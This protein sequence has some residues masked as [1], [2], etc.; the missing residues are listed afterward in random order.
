MS[1]RLAPSADFPVLIGEILRRDDIRER[2]RDHF[3]KRSAANEKVTAFAA[4]LLHLGQV[5][6]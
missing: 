4:A 3:I 2:R 6:R 5:A 1:G